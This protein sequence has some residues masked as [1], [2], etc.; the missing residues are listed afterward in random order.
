MKPIYALVFSP[1]KTAD[2][3]GSKVEPVEVLLFT[4]SISLIVLGVAVGLNPGLLT[5]AGDSLTAQGVE[6]YV[7]AYLNVRR[8][9]G[10]PYG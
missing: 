10:G 1:R 5:P 6:K 8:S 2:M 3:A 9:L 4:M 7:E